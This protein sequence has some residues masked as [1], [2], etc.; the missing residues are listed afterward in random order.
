VNSFGLYL[1]RTD[2][3]MG[4]TGRVNSDLQRG[5]ILVSELKKREGN[6]FFQVSG[7]GLRLGSMGNG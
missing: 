3:R 2:V 5:C 4:L 1:F 7:L 6:P